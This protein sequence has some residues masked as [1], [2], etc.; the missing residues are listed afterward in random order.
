MT[1]DY[2]MRFSSFSD[3]FSLDLQV[4]LMTP[5]LM[6]SKTKHGVVQVASQS[7]VRAVDQQQESE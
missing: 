2:F 7:K 5:K 1:S 3:M 6:Y 4:V